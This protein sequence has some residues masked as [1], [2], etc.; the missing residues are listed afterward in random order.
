MATEKKETTEQPIELEEDDLEQ[1]TGGKAPLVK[2]AGVREDPCAG[3]Q[4]SKQ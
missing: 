1:V 2:P 4:I 3:G